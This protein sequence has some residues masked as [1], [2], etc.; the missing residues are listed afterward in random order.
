MSGA[1]AAGLG[2]PARARRAQ[3]AA[4]AWGQADQAALVRSAS[5]RGEAGKQIT[6]NTR[7]AWAVDLVPSPRR[8]PP[9]RHL[10]P[11]DTAK[12]CWLTVD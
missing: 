2:P 12:D 8:R 4:T 9:A 7:P 11:D 1:V 6:E 5:R 10:E 3:D